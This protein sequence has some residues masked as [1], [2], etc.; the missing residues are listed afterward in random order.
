[1]NDEIQ[2]ILFCNYLDVKSINQKLNR[3]LHLIRCTNALSNSNNSL[4]DFQS[5][6][7]GKP[8]FRMLE[9]NVNP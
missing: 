6:A 5:E 1:M 4:S 9:T 2:F 8:Y 7:I 3:I